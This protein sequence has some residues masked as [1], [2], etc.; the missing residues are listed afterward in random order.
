VVYE[1]FGVRMRSRDDENIPNFE[2]MLNRLDPRALLY[3]ADT[4][5]G[6]ANSSRRRAAEIALSGL[7]SFIR[8]SCLRVAD[9]QGPYDRLIQ[10]LDERK[11]VVSFNWDVLLEG[12]FLRA[13]RSFTYLPRKCADGSTVLLKPH[14]SINWF[15]LLD[16]EL[17]YVAPNS[18]LACFGDDLRIYL[19]YLKDPFGP[20]NFEGSAP[21]HALAPVPAIVAP[22]ASKLLSVGGQPRDGFVEAGH[23]R[24]M[25]A[26]WSVFKTMLDQ[27]S[28]LVVI[29][30]SLP[31]TDAASTELLK[32]FASTATPGNA[33]RVLL[34][35]PNTAVRD[36]YSTLLGLEVKIVC[37]GFGEFDPRVL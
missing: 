19:L 36:R 15:A 5:L 32:H 17:L 9:K 6:G 35:E 10:S 18:N 30:Y 26:I 22:T 31:G 12:A 3:L 29:G 25:T 14:G 16:R 37:G 27:A 1:L 20:V 21:E 11:A 24:A 34:V 4:G 23:A 33:K 13:G 28:E 8:E 2:E 7:R